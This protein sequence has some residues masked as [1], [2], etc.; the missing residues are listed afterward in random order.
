M[1]VY[2]ANARPTTNA[3]PNARLYAVVQRIRVTLHESQRHPS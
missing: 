1:D 3:V 2:I